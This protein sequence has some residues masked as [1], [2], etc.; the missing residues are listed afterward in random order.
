M[1]S[2][3][4]MTA[5][6]IDPQLELTVQGTS[7]GGMQYHYPLS[8]STAFEPWNSMFQLI[9]ELPQP[10]QD[11]GMMESGLHSNETSSVSFSLSTEQDMQFPLSPLEGSVNLVSRMEVHPSLRDSQRPVCPIVFAIWQYVL[12]YIDITI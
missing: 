9:G 10:A 1:D 6:L 7:A 5:A 8:T 4:A 11:V 3:F 12:P 2:E